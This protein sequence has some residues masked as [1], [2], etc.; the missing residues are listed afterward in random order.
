M[1][2]GAEQYEAATPDVVAEALEGEL[3]VINLDTGVYFQGDRAATTAWE[4][5]ISG[6]SLDQISGRTQPELTSFVNEL[7]QHGLIRPRGPESR[8]SVQPVNL[9]VPDGK[10]TMRRF[11]DLAD[12]LALDPVHDVDAVQGW[13]T[14]K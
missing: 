2:I 6:V 9:V 5:V 8:P 1:V 12:M 10:L 13:P 14:R 4:A 11:D 7:L 3:I